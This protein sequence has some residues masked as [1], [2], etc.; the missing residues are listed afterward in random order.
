[1]AIDEVFS[2]PTVKQIIFQIRYPSLFYIENKI[3]DLQTRI[4]DVFSETSLSY[5]KR[6]LL[7]DKGDG[8]DE[9]D[10]DNIS[11]GGDYAKKIWEFRSPQ[12]IKLN[13][14]NDSIDISSEH[15]I[16]YNLGDK[17]EN[18]RDVITF[19]LDIFF[20]LIPVPIINRIGLRYVDE[21]PIPSI[22]HAEFKSW[23]NTCF[24][25]E[26][27]KLSESNEMVFST[28]VKRDECYL[29]YIES[30]IKQGEKIRYNLDFDG[31]ALNIKRE[32][33]L[34]VTDKL[35]TIISNAYDKAIKEHLKEYMK[36]EREI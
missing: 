22:E 2:R 17:E 13:I 29:R 24:P 33:Y 5:R 26:K 15:H 14:S 35:H 20:D 7:V 28:V 1:M 9:K 19:V 25:L 3:G 27:F 21:C 30:F 8:F 34:N 23:Y 12:K 6:L 10:I 18:F 16:T 11:S 32:K 4:M 31:Y 36:G